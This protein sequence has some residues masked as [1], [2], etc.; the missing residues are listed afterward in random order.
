MKF[1]DHSKLTGTH[2]FLSASNWRWLNDDAEKLHERYSRLF[3]TSIGTALHEYARQ[4]IKH[5]YK[6]YKYNIADVRIHLYESGIPKNV[7]DSYDIELMHANLTS[8]VNDA[9]GF[10]MTPEQILFYSDNCYGTADAI[11]FRDNVLRI[12]DLKTGVTATHMEQLM[13]YAALFCLEY[14]QRPGEIKIELAIYQNNEIIEYSPTTE[15]IAH[16]MDQI[17][18]KD[19]LIF[20]FRQEV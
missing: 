10:K 20:K 7:V 13:V 8:F 11:S 18:T 4:R 1:N 19:E 12:H 3:A 5:G 9:I 2:A 16:I 14:M 15:E 6:M 17:K